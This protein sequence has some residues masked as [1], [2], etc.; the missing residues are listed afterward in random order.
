MYDKDI[1]PNW[2]LRFRLKIEELTKEN[3]KLK[4]KNSILERKLNK[5]EN[6]NIRTTGDRQDNNVVRSSR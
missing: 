6:N 4:T 5:Y 1:A 3:E 2:H